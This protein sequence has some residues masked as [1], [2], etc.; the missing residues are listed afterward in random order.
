VQNYTSAPTG[1]AK[2]TEKD[3]ILVLING[4]RPTVWQCPHNAVG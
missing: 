4:T 1:T 2:T 3:V